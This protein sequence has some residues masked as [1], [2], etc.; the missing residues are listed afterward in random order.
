P[1]G[2]LPTTAGSSTGEPMPL[3][4]STGPID[5]PT[6][7]SPDGTAEGTADGTTDTTTTSGVGSST[8][9]SMACGNDLAEGTEVCDGSDLAGEDCQSQGYLGGTLACAADCASF[10]V[11]GCTAPTCGN[12]IQEGPE[13]CDGDDLGGAS[14]LGEGFD[15]GVL[16]CTPGCT[17]DLTG[18]GTC[19]NVIVDGDEVCD[20]I[21]LLGQS[22]V[23]QGFDSGP[24]ACAADCQSYD[25][26]A[27]G[28]C[29]NGFIDGDEECDLMDLGG[30]TCLS[31][32]QEDGVLECSP[33]CTYDVSDC[34]ELRLFFSEDGNPN[35]LYELSPVDGSITAL[36]TSG[37]T[38][39][40]CG[41][42]YDANTG[43]LLGS[44][45]FELIEIQTD[46]S[47]FVSLGLVTAEGLAYDALTNTLY[48]AVN[49]TFFT[50]D[51]SNGAMLSSLPGPGFD[52][53]GLAFDPNQ[54]IVY[55]VGD[56][57]SLVAYDVAA[58]SWSVVGNTGLNWDSGG[59]AFDPN[60]NLLYAVAFAQ[61]T[62]LYT[63]DPATA[64]PTLVGHN[65]LGVLL[66]G[67]LAAQY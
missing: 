45:P 41:L 13:P 32:G 21:V 36:G 9:A 65:G 51:P 11:T 8:G 43:T 39:S 35:G 61:G 7:L 42:T 57:T 29:G 25:T 27:C 16:A 37:V 53:E 34:A 20:D 63:I 30:Q 22:C 23:S 60:T 3:D 56:S 52:V 19:G 44:R 15:S 38:S 64:V 1:E 24:L 18:C 59:L 46:G 67:G 5:I 58:G 49:G 4:S 17:L 40:T 10:D 28:D 2:L 26:S 31:L 55:G 33:S 66:R 48:G 50:I 47:G 14:C 12:G 6:T 62:G 54:G